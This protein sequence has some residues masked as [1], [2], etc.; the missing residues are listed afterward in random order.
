[1]GKI[2][3]STNKNGYVLAQYLVDSADKTIK[4]VV[5]YVNADKLNVREKATKDSK[6]ITSITR[7]D[8]VTYYEIEGEWARITTWT[9][10]NGYVLA[11]Y[12]VNSADKVEKTQVSRSTGSKTESSQPLSV[13]GQT[14]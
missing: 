6:L 5:K 14:W 7:G 3:T 1:M 12:L 10:K 9:D 13:E 11:K 8:K 2:T 4:P